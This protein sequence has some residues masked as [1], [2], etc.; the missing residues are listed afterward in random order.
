M[1]IDLK[2]DHEHHACIV[3]VRG[4]FTMADVTDFA[5][6]LYSDPN[7]A[8]GM[9]LV[10]DLTDADTESLSQISGP[11]Y[12]DFAMQSR[13][14]NKDE[15]VLI[16]IA[17]SDFGFGLARMNQ[18]WTESKREAHVFR[19]SEEAYEHIRTHSE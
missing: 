13:Q 3:T 5:V 7:Y 6:R 8:Q 4:T 12:R 16:V 11:E 2:I 1:P 10:L 17:P 14:E 15:N 9:F 19:T 18:T